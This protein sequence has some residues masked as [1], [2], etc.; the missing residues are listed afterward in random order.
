MSVSFVI[1]KQLEIKHGRYF[2]PGEWLGV[3]HGDFIRCISRNTTSFY[4]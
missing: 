3:T 2:K 4:P 1:V